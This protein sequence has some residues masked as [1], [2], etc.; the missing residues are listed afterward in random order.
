MIDISK[1]HACRN[2]LPASAIRHPG[3]GCDHLAIG[4]YSNDR[5]R[6]GLWALNNGGKW[7]GDDSSHGGCQQK[8]HPLDLVNVPEQRSVKVWLVF[9][10]EWD[11]ENGQTD[12]PH[13]NAYFDRQEGI[14]TLRNVIAQK[15]ITVDYVVGEGLGKAP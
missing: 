2:G 7:A 14:K 6:P 4:T 8:D 3:V 12:K 11:R 13:V 1:P 9:S 10:Y 15:E 5:I